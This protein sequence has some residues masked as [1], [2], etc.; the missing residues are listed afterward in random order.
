MD[1][2]YHIGAGRNTSMGG[3]AW[4]RR[5]ISLPPAADAGGGQLLFLRVGGVHR[6]VTAYANGVYLGHHVG[7]LHEL[8]WDVTAAVAG[9][10]AAA[11]GASSLAVVLDTSVGWR[12]THV[13][14]GGSGVVVALLCA[15][16][17]GRDPRPPPPPKQKGDLP[18][19]ATGSLLESFLAVVSTRTL[20]LL[21][22]GTALR[23]CAGFGLGVWKVRAP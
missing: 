19:G 15:A 1:E 14:V 3:L 12:G 21:F 2:L 13:L 22:A 5:N 11:G 20:Q 9:A 16:L 23:F 4:Y 6:Q 7:Y 10:A 8:E 18:D 17:M